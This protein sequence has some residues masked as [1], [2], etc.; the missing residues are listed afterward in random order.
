MKIK[1]FFRFANAALA[2]F[3]FGAF[4]T[5]FAQDNSF[6]QSDEITIPWP[7]TVQFTECGA[8]LK[9]KAGSACRQLGANGSQGAV[10]LTIHDG[11]E[12]G[13]VDALQKHLEDSENA[14][15]NIP[16]IHVMQSSIL[17]RDPLMGMMEILRNDGTL[18]N[19]ENLRQGTV[20]QTSILIPAGDSLVQVF[21]YLSN[22][23]EASVSMLQTLVSSF[24]QNSVVRI[25]PV[26]PVTVP[27]EPRP[28][29][30]LELLPK[31]LWIGGIIAL[32]G[33]LCVSVHSQIRRARRRRED[34]KLQE[35][36]EA[37]SNMSFEEEDGDEPPSK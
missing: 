15:E 12:L 19:I 4:S 37:C 16:R 26:A 28:S 7:E 17:N 22:D 27:Q 9:A 36:L 30:T 11:Y 13:S 20:R 1:G 10:F 23:D 31:A 14:L 5:A 24:S 18:K 25:P 8:D 34:Q 32:I 2:A 3:V 35:Q 29:G 33:I 21:I 6:F